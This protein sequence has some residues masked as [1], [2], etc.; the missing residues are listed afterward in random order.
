MAKGEQVPYTPSFTF[1]ELEIDPMLKANVLLKNFPN[2]TPI[3]D[4]AIPHILAGKDL[5]GIAGTGTGKTIAFLLPL[6]Q[7][8]TKKRGEKVLI[9]TP[10]RELAEQINDE[11]YLLTKNLNIYSVKCTG[12]GGLRQQI[13]ALSRGYNFIVGTPGRLKDLIDR[14]VLQLTGFTTVVLDEVD[15]MLDMGFIEPIKEL[16]AELPKERQSLFFSATVS[17]KIEG[18]IRIFLKPDFVRVSIKTEVATNQINQGIVRV[19][20]VAEKVIRLQE[21][22]RTAEF[23]KVLVFANTKRGVDRLQKELKAG[24]FNAI[25]IHGDK[26]QNERRNAIRLF[27]AGSASVLIATDVA[28]RGLDIPFVSHVINFDVPMTYDDYIHRIG[29]TGRASRL[30]SALTFV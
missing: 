26:R 9:V 18:V 13:F 23:E 2:P 29:R 25:A 10:T 28:A 16:V 14:R 24:G 15:R 5:L 11:L 6:L 22:L 4:Q 12:G 1:Q 30:G 19:K 21:L 20:T 27:K 7:K 8:I 17:P 3:Q